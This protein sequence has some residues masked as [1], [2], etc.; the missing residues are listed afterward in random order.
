MIQARVTVL[1]GAG[2][3]DQHSVPKALSCT[4]YVSSANGSGIA[5]RPLRTPRPHLSKDGNQWWMKL[6]MRPC[7]ADRI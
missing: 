2:F 6:M 4:F 7:S 1:D 5:I 3:L